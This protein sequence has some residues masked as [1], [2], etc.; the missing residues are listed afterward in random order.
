M[1][2][3]AFLRHCRRRYVNEPHMPPLRRL[4]FRYDGFATYASS[5]AAMP[6]RYIRYAR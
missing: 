2:A 5:F 3:A 4:I 1:P 6:L